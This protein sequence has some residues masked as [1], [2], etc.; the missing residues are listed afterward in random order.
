MA[1][2]LGVGGVDDEAALLRS[3][4]HR[5]GDRS[6]ERDTDEQ[7]TSTHTPAISRG[8][9]AE[10]DLPQLRPTTGRVSP[11]GR[12]LSISA[13]TASATAVASGFPPKVEPV[14]ARG[15]EGARGTVGDQSA[16]RE[17]AADALGERD[18]VG[19]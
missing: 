7:T 5:A 17:A 3:R 18:R 11:P 6:G 13:S 4:D 15:E 1:H 9:E 12:R 10:E 16:D 8:V 19:A 2:G 14:R